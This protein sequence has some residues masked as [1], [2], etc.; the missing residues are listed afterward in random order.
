MTQWLFGK[1]T[2][3]DL[4]VSSS[5]LPVIIGLAAGIAL[6]IVF[7]TSVSGLDLIRKG[8]RPE[9]SS[10]TRTSTAS[11]DS[12]RTTSLYEIEQQEIPIRE[13]SVELI[14]A[15]AR[16]QAVEELDGVVAQ[17]YADFSPCPFDK[18]SATLMREGTVSVMIYALN[19]PVK[20]S[21]EYQAKELEFYTSIPEN[22]AE[23]KAVEVNG[24]KRMG[25]EPCEIKSAVRLD[26]Q[27]FD[28]KQYRDAR[29][30]KFHNE[31]DYTA[32]FVQA[33]GPL[34]EILELARSVQ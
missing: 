10:V 12:G 2:V 31:A 33:D 20:D 5:L 25:W 17:Y 30:V 7:S 21:G 29:G 3:F 9:D 15:N 4:P 13:P 32:Y 28:S 14:S 1:W 19:S 22:P 8:I 26:G 34:S 24:Y 18:G 23:I 11:A 27:V 6:V 16:L